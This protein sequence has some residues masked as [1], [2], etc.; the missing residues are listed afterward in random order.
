MK[1]AITTLGSRGDLQPFIAL[2]LGLRKAGYEVVIIS[3]KNDEAFAKGFG[4]DYHA[5]AVDIQKIMGGDEVQKMTKSDSPLKFI[6]SHLAGSKKMK[7]L[8]VTTQNEIWQACQEVDAIIYH[9]GM[10]NSY[11]IADQLGIPSIMASPFPVTPTKDYPAILFYNGPRL[12]K[13][14]NQLTHFVFEKAFWG[15]SKSAIKEFWERK[16]QPKVVKRTPPAKMQINSGMP[17]LYGYSQLLFKRPDEWPENIQVTGSWMVEDEKQWQ[18]KPE[19]VKFIKNGE[20][21][22]FIGFG[23][24]KD[25]STFKETIDLVSEALKITRQRAVIGLGWNHS[26]GL[27]ALPENIFLLDYAPYTWLFQQMSAVVHHGGAGTLASGLLAGKPTIVI[28][29][30]AD[31]PAWGRRVFEL[32]VGSKPIPRKKLTAQKLADAIQYV[33]SDEIKRKATTLGHEL[34]KETGVEMAVGII[35]GYLKK[36]EST[37]FDYR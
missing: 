26:D 4:L 15:L 20:P 36:I 35:D 29:F 17:V 12:G 28:P 8:M 23:S 21:P 31:Q 34:K 37:F 25:L 32:G 11:Y 16:N 19:L 7:E 3:S 22:L 9:P 14:Y 1:I 33:L 24:M 30:M 5:L 27:E 10:P 6:K 18:P 13:I 2:G